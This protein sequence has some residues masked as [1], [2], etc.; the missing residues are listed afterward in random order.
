MEPN[1][2]LKDFLK[3]NDKLIAAYSIFM[4][5]LVF[6]LNLEESRIK[7][8]LTV[9][10]LILALFCYAVPII[11]SIKKVAQFN[12]DLYFFLILSMLGNLTIAKS[13]IVAVEPVLIIAKFLFIIFIFSSFGG[14]YYSIREEKIKLI[15]VILFFTFLTILFLIWGWYYKTFTMPYYESLKQSGAGA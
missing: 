1:Y 11:G 5:I 12:W 3:E 13:F 7:V 14:I 2:S 4:G 10:F 9:Y 15:H 8:D 6:S